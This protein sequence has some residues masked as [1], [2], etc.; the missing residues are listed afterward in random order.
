MS[1]LKDPHHDDVR[2]LLRALGPGIAVIGLIFMVIGIGSFFASFGSFEPPR[3]FWCAFVGMPL[4]GV[5]L[6]ISKFGYIGSIARYIAS[7]GA[8]VAK[9][10]TNYMVDGTKDSIRNVATAVGEGFAA[11]KSPQ[12]ARCQKCGTENETSANYCRECGAPLRAQKRCAKC[13]DLNDANAR[14]CDHCGAAVT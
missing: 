13:G 3:Y 6:M 12:A 9:D 4:L 2:S 11:A 7:E 14:F 8:P 1:D 10:A 5:G